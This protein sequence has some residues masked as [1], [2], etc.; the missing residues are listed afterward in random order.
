M[1][2]HSKSIFNEGLGKQAA[3]SL[4]MLDFEGVA[5]LIHSN[6]TEFTDPM[7]QECLAAINRYLVNEEQGGAM[8][9]KMRG[10][11][12]MGPQLAADAVKLGDKAPE[13]IRALAPVLRILYD[14]FINAGGRPYT[15]EEIERA[16]RE[17]TDL[18]QA[19]PQQGFT[20]IE[21]DPDCPIHP[22]NQG[23][24]TK[25]PFSSRRRQDVT[26]EGDLN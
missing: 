6:P 12:G 22:R 11:L 20:E 17:Y 15:Q 26:H 10:T 16:Q 2:D 7:W 24:V 4:V 3:Q 9:R 19:P 5:E 25:D 23:K 13:R 8:I 21:H 18:T 14:G 1:I